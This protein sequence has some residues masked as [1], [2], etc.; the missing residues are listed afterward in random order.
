[1]E[2]GAG[3][4]PSMDAVSG[5]GEFIGALD[6]QRLEGSAIPGNG[7]AK[8]DRTHYLIVSTDTD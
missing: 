2:G 5:H 3:I 4:H 8:N 7:D 6:A 1:M